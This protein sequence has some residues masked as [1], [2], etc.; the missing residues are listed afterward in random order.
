MTFLQREDGE[1]GGSYLDLAEVVVR[2]GAHVPRDFEQLWRRI[3]FNVCVSNV[4]DHLR[5]HGFLL[6]SKGWSLAPAYDMN[7]VATGSGLTLDIPET[8]NAQDLA[9]V[10]EVA[11]SFRLKPARATAILAEV[12]AA[13]QTWRA[14]ARRLRLSRPDQDRMA[15]AFRLAAGAV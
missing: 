13:V 10:R 1:P 3:A 12:T 8:D 2:H 14:E 15:P 7:P 11:P 4:D 6:E 5:N 9:L